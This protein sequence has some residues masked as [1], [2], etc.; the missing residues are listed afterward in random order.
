MTI[1]E[2]FKK[3][4]EIRIAGLYAEKAANDKIEDKTFGR[5]QAAAWELAYVKNN[6]AGEK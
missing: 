3:E 1:I 6:N 5:T 4:S 2:K